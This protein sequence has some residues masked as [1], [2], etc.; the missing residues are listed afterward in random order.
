MLSVVIP[1]YNEG[2]NIKN[3]VSQIDSALSSIDYEIVF[4]DDSNDNTPEIIQ[5]VSEEFSNI[6]LEHRENE[7]GLANLCHT[8]TCTHREGGRETYFEANPRYIISCRSMLNI[9][10]DFC[11]S[12]AV[13]L[14]KSL[15]QI[16]TFSPQ[17]VL[18]IL[19]LSRKFW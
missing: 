11:H 18:N 15:T 17:C 9:N 1:T 10:N 7:K 8:Y 3:L 4:V 19:I 5:K 16:M 13:P 6:R 14:W 2:K 12:N